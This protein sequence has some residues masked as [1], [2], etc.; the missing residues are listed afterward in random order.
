LVTAAEDLQRYEEIV[1][2]DQAALAQ[3]NRWLQND[4]FPALKANLETISARLQRLLT[5]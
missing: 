2:K 1:V 3:V 4:T 5:E